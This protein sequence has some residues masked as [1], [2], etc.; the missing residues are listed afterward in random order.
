MQHTRKLL[1]AQSG[2]ELWEVS[3]PIGPGAIATD[4]EGLSKRMPETFCDAR[5]AQ[6]EAW[7]DQEVL[8]CAG[9]AP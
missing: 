5:W 1:K 7:F 8:R 3:L 6:A 9:S 2:V 4:Y